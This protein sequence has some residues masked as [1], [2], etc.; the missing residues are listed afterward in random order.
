MP[1]Q[2]TTTPAPYQIPPADAIFD[3][4]FERSL[5]FHIELPYDT[6]IGFLRRIDKYNDFEAGRVTEAL[7]HID[8]L[9]QRIN[10]APGHPTSGNRDYNISVG[11][12]ASPVI[13]LERLGVR[14]E[15][16]HR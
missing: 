11:R 16:P 14:P 13:Y 4:V 12:E 7:E 9:I 2:V 1:T 8:Q 5:D 15:L 3:A 6:A 10:G